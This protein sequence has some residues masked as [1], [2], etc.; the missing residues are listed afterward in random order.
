MKILAAIILSASIAFAAAWFF[1]SSQNRAALN[2]EQARH[3]LSLKAE[4]DRLRSDDR[5]AFSPSATPA[6]TPAARRV[7]SAEIME[8]LK[9]MRVGSGPQRNQSLRQVVH[10][11]ETLVEQG[12]ESIDPIKTFLALNQDVGYSTAAN[13]ETLAADSAARTRVFTTI[14]VSTDFLVPPSLRLGLMSALKEI[15]GPEAQKVLAGVLSTSGR[16]VEVASLARI[17]EEM[18]PGVYR[19][20][21]LSAAKDLLANP[22]AVQNPDNMDQNTKAYL[23]SVLAL[24]HDTSFVDSA[25]Q[26]LVTNGAL[27]RNALDYL[28]T[29]AK[30]AGVPSL[31]DAYNNPALTNRL[32]K[33]SLASNLLG[34]V[35][36]SP[37]ADQMFNDLVTNTN[38]D[39]RQ[40]SLTVLRLAGINLGAAAVEA[41]KNPVQVAAITGILNNLK[42]TTSDLSI[43]QSIDATLKSLATGQP[44]DASSLAFLRA[45]ATGAMVGTRLTSPVETVET[46][47]QPVQG[48]PRA[49]ILVITP[50]Q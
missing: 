6:S 33:A 22:L 1:L 13:S 38:T 5:P 32:D 10:L 16:G 30:E 35:G 44:L 20:V 24:Y 31:M 8:K 19:D 45:P 26:L 42:Q 23:Y 40:R 14:K 39:P 15:G 50:G 3:E 41:P 28:T 2:E 9:G 7:T 48:R 49:P 4:R 47:R 25:R 11:L 29:T 36:L 18:A 27:D 43:Q 34:F 21:A 46:I 17:L 37:Q 12:T